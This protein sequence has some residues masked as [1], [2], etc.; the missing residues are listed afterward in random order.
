MC[1]FVAMKENLTLL[2]GDLTIYARLFYY[3]RLEENDKRITDGV[4]FPVF[5]NRHHNSIK[6]FLPALN[7]VVEDKKLEKKIT[8]IK[9]KI[10]ITLDVLNLYMLG[11]YI[12]EMIRE[13]YIVLLK[14]PT[15]ETF[16]K[17]GEIEEVT[18]RNKE[19]KTVTTKYPELIK[20]CTDSAK[21]YLNSKG[22]IIETE[23]IGRY[24]KIGSTVEKGIVKCQFAYYLANFLSETFPEAHRNHRGDKAIVSPLEQELVLMLMGYFDLGL[25]YEALTTENFRK[26][27]IMHDNLYYPFDK[28]VLHLKYENWKKKI[29]WKNPA[30]KL[31]L[32]TKDEED[33]I[34]YNPSTL[35]R[36]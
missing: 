18:F 8:C 19:G 10:G 30:L 33:R 34:Y 2:D 35:I 6:D 9:E 14:R 4:Q 22:E 15:K 12:N 13:F 3:S 32:I 17:L 24:D 25:R 29:N 26:L 20:V 16:D 31:N 7:M 23:A 21:A 11:A 1:T 27:I 36:D 5:A 28:N